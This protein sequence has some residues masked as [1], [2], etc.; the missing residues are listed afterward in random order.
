MVGSI[1]QPIL[2][3][4]TA[5]ADIGAFTGSRSISNSGSIADSG[6]VSNS[7]SIADARPV[8]DLGSVPQAGQRR[9]TIAGA[10]ECRALGRPLDTGAFNSRSIDARSRAAGPFHGRPLDPRPRAGSVARLNR[11]TRAGRQIGSR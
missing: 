5:I 7:R 1:G 8:S 6:P 2:Q 10:G 4:V 3:I 11:R 9:G